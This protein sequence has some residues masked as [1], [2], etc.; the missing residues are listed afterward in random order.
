MSHVSLATR[1]PRKALEVVRTFLRGL[2]A[3]QQTYRLYPAGHPNRIESMNGVLAD[4]RRLVDAMDD[5][6][7]FA[8]R[9]SFYLG[10]VLL[11]RESISLRRLVDAFEAAELEAI[12]FLPNVRE[13]DIDHL[14]RILVGDIP[15]EQS[16]GGLH[17][18]RV[19]PRLDTIDSD[20]EAFTELLRAYSIGLDVLRDAGDRIQAGGETD[21]LA[22]RR[23]VDQLA[24]K[25]AFDPAQALLVT[26]VKSYDEYTYYHM[27]NVCILSLALG[28]AVG[29][30]PDQIATLGLGALLHD[31][32][33]IKV[34]LDVL[35][36]VG[37]LSEEQWRLIQKHP[38]DGAGLILVS[39]RDLFDPAVSIV[40]EHHAGYDVS[41]YPRL[42]ERRQP[43][44]PARLVAV[45]DCFDAVTS[46]RSYRQAE[47]RRQALSILQA[48]SGRG[49]DPVVVRAFVRM[50]G[51]FPIGSLVQLEGGEVGLVV[52]NHDRLLARPLIRVVLDRTGTPCDPEE[53]DLSIRAAD[54]SYRW[55]VRRSMDPREV[56]LDMLSLVATGQ[57]EPTSE[58]E[59]GVGLMHEPSHGEA[60]PE[61]YVDTHAEAEY[62]ETGEF[63]IDQEVTA[64]FP[65]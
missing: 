58:D 25:V 49:F 33:K 19:R 12:E 57:V 32:G 41:G 5:P 1:P 40:L 56:G 47:E 64:P 31:V 9:H 15:L 3:C 24:V 44:M 51:I 55:S 61:N 30:R 46:K 54:G 52:R 2:A 38:V 65:S 4:A 29:L 50:L 6:V 48:G 34:P 28:H 59:D 42:S 11:T 45:A 13:G 17:L 27:L 8:T 26:A 35:Q 10:P 21:I 39:S 23:V 22:A 37:A 43:S 53:I 14:I 36:H 20:S 60:R 63:P 18:N 7:L 62:H 16:L